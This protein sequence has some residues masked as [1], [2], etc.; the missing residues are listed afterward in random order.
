[1]AYENNRNNDKRNGGQR[2][3][4]HYSPNLLGC[5]NNALENQKIASL[6]YESRDF[7]VSKR[8]IEPMA[9]IYKNRKRHLVAYCQLRNEYR[10]FRLDRI[11][12]IK[13]NSLGFT[14]RE[15]FDVSIFE[16]DD[17]NQDWNKNTEENSDNNQ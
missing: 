13:V 6:E 17:E 11:N 16:V 2:N 7:E 15:G 3:K 4:M 1:M 14:P 5:I 8:D 10:T 12:L 9:L